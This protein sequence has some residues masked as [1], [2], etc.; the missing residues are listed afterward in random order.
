MQTFD[1]TNSSVPHDI[2]EQTVSEFSVHALDISYPGSH[3]E[4]G[5]KTLS[6]SEVAAEEIK[7]TP[8]VGA[9]MS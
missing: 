1:E 7:L 9:V 6:E 8:N 2:A 5:L 4:H 3:V